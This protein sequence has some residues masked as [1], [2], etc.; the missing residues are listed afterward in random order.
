MGDCGGR[1]VGVGVEREDGSA[2]ERR[3]AAGERGEGGCCGEEEGGAGAVVG[4]DLGGG[5][6]GQCVR[7]DVRWA[8]R[9]SLSEVVVKEYSCMER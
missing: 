2:V 3:G 5:H 7:D 4:V 9:R 6:G 1:R 8:Y